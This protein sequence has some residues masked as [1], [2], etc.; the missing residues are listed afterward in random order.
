M[1]K[2]GLPETEIETYADSFVLK[3]IGQQR[4]FSVVVLL[5]DFGWDPL[6]AAL[7]KRA[8]RHINC[9]LGPDSVEHEILPG[10][11]KAVRITLKKSFL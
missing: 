10:Y 8:K 2:M 1:M 7:E 11:I 4:G 9:I 5:E 3:L 6:V